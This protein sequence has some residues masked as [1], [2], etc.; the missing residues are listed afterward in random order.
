MGRTP[1][2]RASL[3]TSPT[4]AL[5]SDCIFTIG[6]EQ[7]KE[8][9]RSGRRS[10]V[11]YQSIRGVS[12]PVSLPTHGG[13]RSK[14]TVPPLRRIIHLSRPRSSRPSRSISIGPTKAKRCPGSRFGNSHPLANQAMMPH[15]AMI[16]RNPRNES[17]S[18]RDIEVFRR[19]TQ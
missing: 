10:S 16:A 6:S 15:A 1:S 3:V 8:M 4:R 14:S 17:L 7:L 13:G 19:L 2:S 11:T 5:S 12:L 9:P 18:L